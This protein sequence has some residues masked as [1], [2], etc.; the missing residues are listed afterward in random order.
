MQGYTQTWR[1]NRRAF[2]DAFHPNAIPQY[3]PIHLRQCHRF[4]QRLLEEPENFIALARQ[5]V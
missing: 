4:L 1:K 5:Y 3:R 2:H